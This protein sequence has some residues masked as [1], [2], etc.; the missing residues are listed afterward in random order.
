MVDLIEAVRDLENLIAT[1]A[2]PLTDEEVERIWVYAF[3][4]TTLPNEDNAQ[5]IR[6]IVRRFLELR[7][8]DREASRAVAPTVPS[9]YA[10]PR[11]YRS[12]DRDLN[13]CDQDLQ[14]FMGENGDW[15]VSIVKHGERCGP[16]VRVTTS[17][18]PRG[19]EGVP[20]AV[21]QLYL[22]MKSREPLGRI[23]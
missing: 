19:L 15:Y 2:I 20:L 22:A 21:H 16:C 14:V 11:R 7:D 9:S 4:L 12:D 1:I 3:D 8:K 10:E 23:D 6:D 5:T 18:T 17:G 13:G